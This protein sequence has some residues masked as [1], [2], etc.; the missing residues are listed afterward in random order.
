MLFRSPFPVPD[1]KC[2]I[3]NGMYWAN[4]QLFALTSANYPKGG[5][6]ARIATLDPKTE[7]GNNLLINPRFTGNSIMGWTL[8][9]GKRFWGQEYGAKRFEETENGSILHL[10][11]NKKDRS[12]AIG[13]QFQGVQAGTYEFRFDFAI[14]RGTGEIRI[15]L[16]QGE[17]EQA[18]TLTPT[19][20]YQTYTLSDINLNDG[21]LALSIEIPEDGADAVSLGNLSFKRVK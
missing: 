19:T 9:D 3:W 8:T 17:T 7:I 11:R 20:D 2:A 6:Y 16:T 4:N 1:G 5:I 18:F 10:T 13:Q 15:V 14:T 21:S 12:L